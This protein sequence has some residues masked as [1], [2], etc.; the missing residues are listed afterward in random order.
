M[1]ACSPRSRSI[2]FVGGGAVCRRMPSPRA[3][4][5]SP[6]F[7][8]ARLDWRRD[9]ILR[10]TQ[11]GRCRSISWRSKPTKRDGG[12]SPRSAKVA[13]GL[14]VLDGS[15]TADQDKP[16]VHRAS[17]WLRYCRGRSNALTPGQGGI[18]AAG[19]LH[20]GDA[21]ARQFNS[22]PRP[23]PRIRSPGRSAPP[24]VVLHH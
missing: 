12:A 11:P 22:Y 9:F 2:W 20:P 15:F 8:P 4:R 10:G 6:L 5:R 1:D 21:D 17:R 19:R 23:A 14:T 3:R 16:I 24:E 13:R 18:F 7:D